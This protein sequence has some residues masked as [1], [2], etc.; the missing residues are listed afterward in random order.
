VAQAGVTCVRGWGTSASKAT[1]WT[2]D[3]FRTTSV[4]ASG[5]YNPATLAKTKAAGGRIDYEISHLAVGIEV[6]RGNWNATNSRWQRDRVA[7][8]RRRT[9]GAE[10]A[11]R[12][13]TLRDALTFDP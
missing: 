5:L 7:R 8:R 1:L 13:A 4:G 9:A 11:G 10:I 3:E 6:F 2:R 12:M